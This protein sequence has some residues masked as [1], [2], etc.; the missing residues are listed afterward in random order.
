MDEHPEGPAAGNR[1]EA[2]WK[3][4]TAR[5]AERNTQTRKVAKQ[6]REAYERGQA[7]LRRAEERRGMSEL[8]RRHREG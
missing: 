7:E 4:A 1:G 5:V 2:A 8:L 6:R 3:E